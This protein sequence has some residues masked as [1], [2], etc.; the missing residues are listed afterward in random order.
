[1][2][3]RP[4][5]WGPRNTCMGKNTCLSGAHDWTML[6]WPIGR[7]YYDH[8]LVLNNELVMKVE[9][10]HVQA[11]NQVI[12]EVY[13]HLRRLPINHALLR[14]SIS[15]HRRQAKR[16]YHKLPPANSE[17]QIIAGSNSPHGTSTTFM[18]N[19]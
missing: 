1:M 16:L 10:L 18:K 8:A 3:N 17:S 14:L 7:D 4:G 12:S 11:R 9:L 2:R 13:I 5:I 6:L 19:R 15:F